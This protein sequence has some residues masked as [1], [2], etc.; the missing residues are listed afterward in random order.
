MSNDPREDNL[1]VLIA[2]ESP[3]RLGLITDV[4]AGLGHVVVAAGIEVDEIGAATRRE[5]PD[6]ALARS[7]RAPRMP[8][9]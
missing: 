5:R 3:E 8:S 2:N 7:A 9:R 1:R 4:L 6:V